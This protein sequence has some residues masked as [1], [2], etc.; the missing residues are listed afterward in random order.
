MSRSEAI[1]KIRQL[2]KQLN[3]YRYHYYSLDQPQVSDREYDDL[4]DSLEKLEEEYDYRLPD[5][6]T[7]RIGDEP[8]KIL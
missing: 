2:V 6:P 1:E 8:L 7:Q 4:Y 3:Q 5:S